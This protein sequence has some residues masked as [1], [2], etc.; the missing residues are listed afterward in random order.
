MNKVDLKNI[1]TKKVQDYT[2][3]ILFLLI[4]SIFIIFAINPSLKTAFSLTKEKKI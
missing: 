2:Y 1:F 4:F 3:V